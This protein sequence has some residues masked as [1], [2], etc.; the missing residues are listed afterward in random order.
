MGMYGTLCRISD[1]QLARITASPDRVASLLSRDGPVRSKPW[2][3]LRLDKAWDVLDK[4]LNSGSDDGPLADAIHGVHGVK[5]GP[6]LSYGRARYLTPLQVRATADAL[7]AFPEDTFRQRWMSGALSGAYVFGAMSGAQA[8]AQSTTPY[9]D[10]LAD[11]VL[12]G[13]EQD[14]LEEIL[15]LLRALVR[16]YGR[17]ARR[18]DGMIMAVM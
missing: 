3:I 14:P 6:S 11:L 9:D 4:G 15:A 17:A 18:G 8:P 16:F 2:R 5:I 12:P 13:E 7:L 1:R 10:L